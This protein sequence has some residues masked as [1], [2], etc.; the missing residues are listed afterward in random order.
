LG[1]IQGKYLKCKINFFFCE[2]QFFYQV[3]VMNDVIKQTVL[4]QRNTKILLFLLDIFRSQR[5]FTQQ[6]HENLLLGFIPT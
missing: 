2:L 4:T 5:L 3:I 6:R 1:V